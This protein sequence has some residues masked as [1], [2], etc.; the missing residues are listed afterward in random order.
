[1]GSWAPFGWF[2]DKMCYFGR[3]IIEVCYPLKL[4]KR[5]L[6][7]FKNGIFEQK[8]Q[9]QFFDK[10]TLVELKVRILET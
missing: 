9:F 1:M 8:S 6:K 2:Y 3:I 10:K 4:T 7:R 5:V